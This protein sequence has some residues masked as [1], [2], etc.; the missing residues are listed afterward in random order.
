[1]DARTA[2]MEEYGSMLTIEQIEYKTNDARQIS[3]CFK[4]HAYCFTNSILCR[5]DA[6]KVSC[7][8][9]VKE[10]LVFF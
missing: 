6:G 1:M 7:E 4:C 5:C 10:V 3:Q 9:H 2:L 8:T